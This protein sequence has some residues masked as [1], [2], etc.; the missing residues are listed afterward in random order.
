M[1]RF[2]KFRF[3]VVGASAI[4]L[5]MWGHTS[6]V[7]A[8]DWSGAYGGIH[9]GYLTGTVDWDLV[10]DA[11]SLI[12][13]DEPSQDVDGFAGGL[14]LGY[15]MQTGRW[16]WGIEGTVSLTSADD[17]V[18]T[19]GPQNDD[20]TAEVNTLVSAVGRLGYDL[21]NALVYVRAGYAGANVDLS[22]FATGGP[23]TWFSEE[24]H[25]GWTVGAGLA[26]RIAPNVLLGVQY[27]YISLET[28]LHDQPDDDG[29][30][31]AYDIGVDDMHNFNVRLTFQFNRAQPVSLK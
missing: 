31:V 11:S 14:H 12:N 30:R 20:H 4:C 9:A 27:D 3:A 24:W 28:K 6:K 13:G 16:V 2:N 19:I 22:I 15:Q 17:F 29:D 10:A 25:H 7:H 26:Y 23:D 5:A 18:S 1:L 21:G 8:A